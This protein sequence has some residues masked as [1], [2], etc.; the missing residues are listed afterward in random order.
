MLAYTLKRLGIALFVI[1]T[2]SGL[3]FTFTNLAVDP[4]RAIAGEQARDEDIAR[5]RAEYGFDRPALVQYLDW[6]SHTLTGDLG[7]SIRERRPVVEALAEAFPVTITLSTGAISLALLIAVPLGIAAALRPNSWVDQFSQGLAVVGMAMPTF[8]FGLLMIALF[9]IRLRWLPIS[10]DATLW[11]FI[12]PAIA[13]AYYSIPIIMRLTRAGMLD[14]LATD[15][16]RTARAKGLLPGKVLF[17][18]ALRNAMLPLVSVTAVQFGHLLAGSVV[19]EQVFALRGVGFLAWRSINFA[20]LPVVQAV[21]LVM[22]LIYVVLVLFADLLN[23]LLDP[24]IR[25]G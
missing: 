16:I 9:G 19:V 25:L 22:A 12:M 21:V 24:R 15:Y 18:H 11:H 14:V 5:I 4:A 6:L 17:K 7:V 20:D 10:G 13:L 3:T 8:W 2:V 23:A 1:F